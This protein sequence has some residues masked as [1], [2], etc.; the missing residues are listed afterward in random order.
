MLDPNEDPL[1][2][3]TW[4]SSVE[5]RLALPD[6]TAPVGTATSSSMASET[7]SPVGSSTEA[8]CKAAPAYC[9]GG[10]MKWE[11]P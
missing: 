5:T 4:G 9:G 2:A 11:S 8:A 6:A 3:G 10:G 7:A 1:E